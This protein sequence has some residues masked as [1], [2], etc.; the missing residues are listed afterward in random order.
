[1][2]SAPLV[3]EL[4][5]PPEPFEALCA[6]AAWPDAVLLESVRREGPRSRY[7]FLTADPVW[8][9]EIARPSPG[10]DPFVDV[11]RQLAGYQNRRVP[12]L[13]PFQGGAVGLLGYEL[14]GSFESLPRASRDEFG[15]PALTVGIYD[16][17]LAW[18]HVQ[19]RAWLIAQPLGPSSPRE[20]IAA[21][22]QRLRS[23]SPPPQ[24]V[25]PEAGMQR[26]RILTPCHP[27]MGRLLSNFSRDG[28]LRAAERVI[29][30]IRAGDIFQA[31]LSQRLLA[32]A[33]APPLALYGR[34]RTRNP[35][36]FAACVLHDDWAV[37]SASP[38]RFL[39]VEQDVVTTRP[40]KGTRSRRTVPEADLLSRDELRESGKDRAENIM[41]V[42]LLR[43]D[44]SRVCRPGSIRVGDLCTVETYETVQ[45]LVSEVQGRLMAGRDFWDLLAATFP[46]GS[47]TGAP[48]VRAMEII[49]ELEQVARGAYCGSLFYLG[50]DGTADSSILIRTFTQRGGWIQ[51]PVGGGIVAQ[52]DPAAEYEETLHKAEG[53]LRAL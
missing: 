35:A 44:L 23:G 46:G 40:I 51:C 15:L 43:N 9:Q 49:T 20:R 14:G 4:S 17:V 38:E 16:W 7:S 18:D 24:A 21:V 36:P 11:R 33:E 10:L 39:Q 12:D 28:Y 6:L 41:I 8:S 52:S 47:I 37:L 1:M 27:L 32:P 19:E 42:D 25:V 34:L 2:M 29:E 13:P 31:N 53:M 5:P 50:F 48:K 26:R 3:Q 22:T 30:Y 45:H